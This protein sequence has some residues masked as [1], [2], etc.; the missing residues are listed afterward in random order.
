ML[1]TQKRLRAQ[2]C[3]KGLKADGVQWPRISVLHKSSKKLLEV[4]VQRPPGQN[5]AFI[6]VL[7]QGGSSES[8]LTGNPQEYK[9]QAELGPTL[10]SSLVVMGPHDPSQHPL[11]DKSLM[12]TTDEDMVWSKVMARSP[13][14]TLYAHAQQHG[15]G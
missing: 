10:P 1:E 2:S 11:W 9:A 8:F 14:I 7:W 12:Y 6:S 4:H 15:V 3:P 5:T 13:K